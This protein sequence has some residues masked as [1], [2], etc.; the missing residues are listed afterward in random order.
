MTI[1][2]QEENFIKENKI[3]RKNIYIKYRNMLNRCYNKTNPR[4]IDYGG[5]GIIVCKEWLGKN[6]FDNFYIWAKNNGFK[7]KLQLDKDILSDKLNIKL[8]YYSPETCKFVTASVNMSFMKKT[9]KNTSGYIGVSKKRSR[10]SVELKVNKIKKRLGVY[11]TAYEA[12]ATRESYIIINKIE[13]R[14]N[15]VNTFN[16]WSID[17]SN[18]RKTKNTSKYIGIVKAKGKFTG[19]V[20]INNKRISIGVYDTELEAAKKRNNIIILNNIKNYKLN[21]IN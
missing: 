21:I 4:Y 19:N 11:A 18:K 20:K 14:L 2:K 12:A 6:G 9:L 8:P 7:H 3:L 1:I 10:Y 13:S 17:I 16:N 15:N 5:K